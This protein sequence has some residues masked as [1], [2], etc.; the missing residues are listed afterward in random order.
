MERIMVAMD[1]S[2]THLFVAIHALNL[3][4]R[5]NAR[6]FFLLVSPAAVDQPGITA[7]N[8]KAAAVKRS[9]DVLIDDARSDGIT[10]EYYAAYGDYESELIRFVQ[11]NKVTL[12][13]IEGAAG[14]VVAAEDFKNFL[15]RLRHRINCRIEVVNEKPKHADRKE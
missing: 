6:V 5:I 7:E 8:K 9:V 12:L 4:R 11:D 1:P 15:D 3:A 10:V 14:S 2:R 13:V